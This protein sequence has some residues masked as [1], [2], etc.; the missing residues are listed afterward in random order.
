MWANNGDTISRQYAGTAALKVTH[1]DDWMRFTRFM[2]TVSICLSVPNTIYANILK[3]R[4]DIKVK[5]M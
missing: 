4:K 3:Y 2:W 5:F 1:R